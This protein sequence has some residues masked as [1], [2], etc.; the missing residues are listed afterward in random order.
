MVNDKKV[1]SMTAP[2]WWVK[3]SKE[4]S[5]SSAKS[6]SHVI[7]RTFTREAYCV[8]IYFS[9]T[10][11]DSE[12]VWSLKAWRYECAEASS[13]LTFATTMLSVCSPNS[14]SESKQWTIEHL[15]INTNIS[16]TDTGT[17][18]TPIS[19][20]TSRRNQWKKHFISLR[21]GGRWVGWGG[22]SK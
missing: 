7:A 4:G 5:L 3:G 22:G 19:V 9:N 12:K 10:A 6:A 14:L 15:L 1:T 18:G 13:Y 17:R 20:Q 2:D 8:Y 21:R 11:P 16:R